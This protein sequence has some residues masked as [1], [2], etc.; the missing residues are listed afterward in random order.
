MILIKCWAES[1]TLLT[2]IFKLIKNVRPVFVYFH[3]LRPSQQIFSHGSFLVE[4]VLSRKLKCHA[5]G[6]NAVPP[7]RLGP[8]TPRAGVKH[9]T[10]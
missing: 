2:Q 4:P 7:T 8:T 1:V 5:Q 9:S 3:S 10:T 6:L